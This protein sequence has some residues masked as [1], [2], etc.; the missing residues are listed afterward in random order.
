MTGH[1]NYR[2]VLQVEARSCPQCRAGGAMPDVP[3]WS[4]PALACALF[5]ADVRTL[6]T[7]RRAETTSAKTS[8]AR[9]LQRGSPTGSRGFSRSGVSGASTS[10]M[11]LG[12]PP[13]RD[14]RSR[15]PPSE[16]KWGAVAPMPTDGSARTLMTPTMSLDGPPPGMVLPAPAY[17]SSR[18]TPS[19][20]M[21]GHPPGYLRANPARS[22]E[23]HPPG[24]FA[25]S[26]ANPARSMEG[27]PPGAALPPLDPKAAAAAQE[28][29]GGVAG[30]AL[31]AVTVIMTGGPPSAV[32][33]R[34]PSPQLQLRRE[35][36]GRAPSPV[37][38]GPE[39]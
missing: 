27:H 10:S 28:A 14:A 24:Y 25:L 5:V 32:S 1:S 39:T 23:G 30:P 35:P 6:A 16:F 21:E 11:G 13:S 17:A 29:R 2:A 3:A 8:L 38:R 33:T 22:M 37:P 18:A 20:S 34:A 15:R 36:L 4:D 7:V 31:S 19:M 9:K 26:R 12:R